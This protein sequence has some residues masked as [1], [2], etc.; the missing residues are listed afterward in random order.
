MASS[1]SALI[2]ATSTIPASPR[3]SLSGKATKLY[4]KC[5]EISG[6]G[7]DAIFY[8]VD[9]AAFGAA[10][11][12]EELKELCEH[13][14]QKHLFQVLIEGGQLCWR[15]RSQESAKVYVQDICSH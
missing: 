14:T 13:L 9:L 6:K 2:N 4:E 12:N 7:S 15:I 3:N 8:Q 5:A 1:S 10:E 11:N